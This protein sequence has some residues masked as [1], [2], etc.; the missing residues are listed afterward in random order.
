MARALTS[1]SMTGSSSSRSAESPASLIAGITLKRPQQFS[2]DAAEAAVRHQHDDVPFAMFAD[3]GR[4][5]FVVV[6]HM[7]GVAALRTQVRDE[8]VGIQP[9]CLWKRRSKHGGDDDLVRGLERHRKG[10]LEHATAR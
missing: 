6:G 8:P 4:D 7:T 9:L 2:M 3:D 10:V 5:D 1:T